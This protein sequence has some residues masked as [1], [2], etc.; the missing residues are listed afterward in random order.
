MEHKMKRLFCFIGL[1]EWVIT[2]RGP[3]IDNIRD[4]GYCGFWTLREC[5]VC[6]KSKY[7]QYT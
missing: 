2:N 5:Q 1:H 7:K 6:C 3:V 4:R